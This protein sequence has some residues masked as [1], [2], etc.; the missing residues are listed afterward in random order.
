MSTKEYILVIEGT[1]PPCVLQTFAHPTSP[2][3]LC[4]TVRVLGVFCRQSKERLG[5]Q[6]F[7]RRR[8][9]LSVLLLI[10]ILWGARLGYL[11]ICLNKLG[12][13]KS[14]LESDDITHHRRMYIENCTIYYI[15]HYIKIKN[16]SALHG[17]ESLPGF[18]SPQGGLRG[19]RSLC[20][21]T[22]QIN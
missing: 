9:V 19:D 1:A 16:R 20:E 7:W 22:E 18:E 11:C 2:C 15:M 5:G 6:M 21:Y 13:C 12:I 14:G 4:Q 8:G 17:F 3:L 10:Y